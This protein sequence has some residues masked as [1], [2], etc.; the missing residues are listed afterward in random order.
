MSDLELLIYGFRIFWGLVLGG[1]LAGG[2]RGSWNAE[3]GKR[4][5]LLRERS[6]TVVWLDPICFPVLYAVYLGAVLF[7]FSVRK[8]VGVELLGAGAA[9][10]FLFISIIVK[11]LK[12]KKKTP[13]I[14]KEPEYTI[15]DYHDTIQ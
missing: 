1:F 6:D 13:I 2:F 15:H 3:N 5:Y 10:M 11:I 7:S 9:D 4:G 8:D 14:L 12:D